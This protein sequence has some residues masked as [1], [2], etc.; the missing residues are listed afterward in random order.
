MIRPCEKT[1]P[2]YPYSQACSWRENRSEVNH[3][4][5]I[6]WKVSSFYPLTATVET[7]TAS[8]LHDNIR[9]NSHSAVRVSEGMAPAVWSVVCS[10][11]V[12]CIAWD[13]VAQHTTSST[14]SKQK[15]ETKTE[16]F[17]NEEI[18]TG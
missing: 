8:P 15:N 10:L 6:V 14:R 18:S 11:V 16:I 3:P 4:P 5:T 17:S 9:L 2:P 12:V 7:K 1:C 13:D